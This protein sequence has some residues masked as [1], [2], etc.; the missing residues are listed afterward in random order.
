MNAP[1]EFRLNKRLAKDSNRRLYLGNWLFLRVVRNIVFKLHLV[2][3]SVLSWEN[4]FLLGN[5]KMQ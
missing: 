3:I 2:I 1:Q 5:L 4:S